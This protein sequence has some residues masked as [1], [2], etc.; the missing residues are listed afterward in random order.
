VSR[1]V[2]RYMTGDWRRPGGYA[3]AGGAAG[4]AVALFLLLLA[5]NFCFLTTRK[6]CSRDGVGGDA[7]GCAI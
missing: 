5:M 4:A 7:P 1:F 3:L 6:E 2:R